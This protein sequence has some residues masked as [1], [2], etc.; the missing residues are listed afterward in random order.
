MYADCV[1]AGNADLLVVMCADGDVN[2]VILVFDLG[3]LNITADRGISMYLDAGREDKLDVAIQLFLRQTV[4]RNAVSK[5]AAELRTL[6]VYNNPVSHQ[7]QKISRRQA[8]RTA[9]DNG[10]ALSGGRRTGRGRHIGRVIARKALDAAD[11]HRVVHHAAA[12]VCLARVLA[13][14]AAYRGEGVFLSDQTNRIIITSRTHERDITRNIDAGRTERHAGHRMVPAEQAAAVLNMRHIVVA[15]AL[16]ALE[17]HARRLVADSAVRRVLNNARGLFNKV[18]RLRRRSRVQHAF[19]QLG[20]LTQTNAAR[21]TFAAGL[22]MAQTQ[23]RQR[24]I[25]RTQTRR[26]GAD[27]PLDIAVQ[28]GNDGLSLARRFNG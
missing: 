22:C 12:A 27:A 1:F 9:A 18:N 28:A 14:I 4:V 17:H 3:E 23:E 19:Q 10:N 6:V 2:R 13:D 11:V 21:N 16:H 26:T 15:E 24:H 7:R 5:H 20:Q 8:A 25:H